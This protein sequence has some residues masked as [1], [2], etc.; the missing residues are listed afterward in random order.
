MFKKFLTICIAL[1]AVMSLASCKKDPKPAERTYVAD[2]DY[3]A[4]KAE[5]YSGAPMV[6]SVTVTI[7]D[8]KIE[9][10]YINCTQGKALTK[11]D[12]GEVVLTAEFNEKSK[13]ELGYEYH[14]H[15]YIGYAPTDETP[16]E[17]EY[18]AWLKSNNKLEW[19]EQA[20]RIEAA[21]LANGVDSVTVDAKSVIN[22]VTGVTIKDGGYIALAKEAV[23]NAKA[24]KVQYY[25]V[26][27]D[28]VIWA[29]GKVNKD[30]GL[31]EVVID[32]L[33]GAADRSGVAAWKF[34]AKSKQQLG[35]GYQMF[36]SGYKA[37]DT[38]PTEAEYIEWLKANNKLE[39]F[40]QAALIVKAYQAN[41]S[42]ILANG[43][44]ASVAGV[45]ISDN[46]YIKVLAGLYAAV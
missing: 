44:F 35:Y 46:N 5:V 3:T 13:K 7:K 22:N 33:Q 38:T 40:E 43:E 12:N 6:T 21:W 16:T 2:G 19:F 17:A 8:D 27:Q 1:I 34:N 15:Y 28:D 30:G 39:W 32:T 26:Y 45:T 23:D 14:M 37:E 25:A 36:Y 24:G 20:A 4:F 41:G 10:Y 42:S 9:K 18:I 31:S 11:S 29:S